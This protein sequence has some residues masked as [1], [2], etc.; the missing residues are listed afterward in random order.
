MAATWPPRPICRGLVPPSVELGADPELRV[1]AN[2]VEKAT[3]DCLKPVVPAL[4]M[5]LPST[6]IS[7][8]F[9][10]RPLSDVLSAD[11]KPMM[12]PPE[13][14][15]NENRLVP[16]SCYRHSAAQIRCFCCNQ[17][18]VAE[19]VRVLSLDHKWRYE[20]SRIRPP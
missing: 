4:E 7:V 3:F 15:A 11:D 10:A 8:S 16:R 6:L 20:F 9:R 12:T 1:F 2:C 18:K 19:L 13:A 14:C 17:H 5:L